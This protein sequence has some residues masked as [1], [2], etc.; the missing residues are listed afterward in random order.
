MESADVANAGSERTWGTAGSF[1]GDVAALFW[2]SPSSDWL[3]PRPPAL[4]L[5]MR[6][7]VCALS[8]LTTDFAPR[9]A[10]H[11]EQAG[12]SQEKAGRFRDGGRRG[13]C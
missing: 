12:C 9:D 7:G 1:A 6:L 3:G 13:K 5:N 10:D 11:A 8:S 4:P 2:L